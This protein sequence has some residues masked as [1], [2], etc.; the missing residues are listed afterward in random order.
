MSFYSLS[1]A[2]S[3]G[4]T[5][6]MDEFRGKVIYATNVASLWGKTHRE[7]AQFKQ[8]GERWG[9]K[10]V[11]IAF[12]SNEFG[13]QEYKSDKEIEAFAISKGFPGVLMQLGNVLGNSAPEVWKYMKAE[14][15]ASDPTWNF[16]GKFLVS[17]TGKIYVPTNV[18]KD[19]ATL[20]SE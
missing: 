11:I 16:D 14:S 7:Y 13:S 5:I 15:R 19:I 1:A 6:A 3:S 20:I 9:D 8:L 18:E 10:L 17:K 12:P 4:E 2:I